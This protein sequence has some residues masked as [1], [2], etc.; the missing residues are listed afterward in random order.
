MKKIVGPKASTDF[1]MSALTA[2]G[3][4]LAVFSLNAVGV[5]ASEGGVSQNSHPLQRPEV[6]VQTKAEGVQGLF[7]ERPWPA[8]YVALIKIL[9]KVRRATVDP[10]KLTCYP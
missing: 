2:D 5:G 6:L 8:E 7:K 10:N 4:S 9:L 1:Y 3:I